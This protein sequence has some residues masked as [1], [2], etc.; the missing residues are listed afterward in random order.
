M[1]IMESLVVQIIMQMLTII[2][3]TVKILYVIKINSKDTNGPNCV[4]LYHACLR[5]YKTMDAESNIVMTSQRHV[6]LIKM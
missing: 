3:S 6:H 2:I 1:E 5:K 4:N